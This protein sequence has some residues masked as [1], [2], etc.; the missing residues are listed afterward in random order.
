MQYRC[1]AVSPAGFVKQLVNLIGN[2]YHFF[3]TGVIPDGKDPYA[4]DVKLIE[5]Y[6]LH[7]GVESEVARRRARSRQKARGR[8]SVAYL[9]YQRLFVLIATAGQHRFF[10]AM[11]DPVNPG[12][13]V[14][15]PQCGIDANSNSESTAETRIRDIRAASI[16]FYGYRIS[17][18]LASDGKSLHAHVRIDDD[19]YRRLKAYL[20][21][22]STQRPTSALV[23][24]IRAIPFEPYHAVYQQIK[25]IVRAMNRTRKHRGLHDR[26]RYADIRWKRW[27]GSPFVGEP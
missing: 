12:E 23:K 14:R 5:K 9:R 21:D 19:D 1:E 22:L 4:L 27:N 15:K 26:V 16:R 2:N 3:V 20:V 18:R 10:N 25:H 17:K 24:E 13:S 6:R 8:A 11:T 7:L